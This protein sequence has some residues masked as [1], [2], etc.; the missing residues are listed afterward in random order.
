M[1]TRGSRAALRKACSTT[2][3][4][5]ATISADGD[6]LAWDGRSGRLLREL[7]SGGWDS[8][9]APCADGRIL[10]GPRDGPV[11]LEHPQTAVGRQRLPE[12]GPVCAGAHL[13]DDLVAVSLGFTVRIVDASSGRI[14]GELQGDGEIPIRWL[15]ATPGGLVVGGGQLWDDSDEFS[16][17]LASPPRLFA[18]EA[19]SGRRIASWE[20]RGGTSTEARAFALRD[21]GTVLAWLAEDTSAVQKLRVVTWDPVKRRKRKC[22]PNDLERV[23]ALDPTA[24]LK[25][26]H[27]LSFEPGPAL[28]RSLRDVVDAG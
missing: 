9:L 18:W 19:S 20:A 12:L 16:L 23:L 15:A 10:W 17:Q 5:L 24:G 8:I 28:S 11:Y 27:V 2:E 26:A 4:V 21:D 1:G 25:A 7:G 13:R 14:G 3:G 22:K 6:V